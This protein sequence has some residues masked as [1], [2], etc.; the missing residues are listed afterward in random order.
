MARPQFEAFLP[1][2][3]IDSYLDRLESYFIAYDIDDSAEEKRRAILLSCVGAETYTVL[4]DLSF[5]SKPT[6]KSYAQIC[7]LLRSHF[8][9]TRNSVTERFRFHS[10]RQ[11]PGQSVTAF[12]AHLRK[13]AQHC[14]FEGAQ[15]LDSLRDRFIAGLRSE[16]IQRKLLTANVSFQD[17]VALAVAAEAAA[18]DVREFVGDA[19]GARVERVRAGP[20]PATKPSSDDTRAGGAQAGPGKTCYRCGSSAHLASGCRHQNTECNFCH[21][22]GHLERVCLK[23][24][25]RGGATNHVAESSGC[26]RSVLY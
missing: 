24:K 23:K 7:V 3:D 12:A 17:A 10:A 14:E 2:G 4:R 22:K 6:E 15:L 9:P 16:N 19:A 25:G 18:K 8:L 13:L 1:D 21:K 5:P 20:A 11:Q 26:F